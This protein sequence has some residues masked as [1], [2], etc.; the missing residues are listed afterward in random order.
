MGRFG[1]QTYVAL[2]LAYFK[3]LVGLSI[4]RVTLAIVFLSIRVAEG[5]RC[6]FETNLNV[7]DA[8][9]YLCAIRRLDDGSMLL[10]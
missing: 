7:Y 9:I 5:F 6:V 4:P 1:Q 3:K 10:T 8:V 2:S